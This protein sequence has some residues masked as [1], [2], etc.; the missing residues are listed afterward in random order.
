MAAVLVVE[1]GGVAGYVLAALRLLSSLRSTSSMSPVMLLA[2]V[3]VTLVLP[4]VLLSLRLQLTLLFSMPIL[5]SLLISPL[6]SLFPL[7]QLLQ[8]SLSTLR[9]SLL[10]LRHQGCRRQVA[11]CAADDA[12]AKVEA[13]GILHAGVIAGTVNAG[14]SSRIVCEVAVT[15]S[16]ITEA[17]GIDVAGVGVVV[18]DAVDVAAGVIVTAGVEGAVICGGDIFT[19]VIVVEVLVGAG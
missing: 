7:R 2:V 9:V 6:V 10:L 3:S 11:R 16:G 14:W 12:D 17:D 19:A 5:P 4:W 8:R 13:T 15:G 1:G 18:A